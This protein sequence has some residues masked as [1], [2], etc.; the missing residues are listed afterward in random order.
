MSNHSLTAS[1]TDLQFSYTSVVSIRQYQNIICRKTLIC[2][3]LFVGHMV[4]SWSIK[5][6]AGKIA[7]NDNHT[8]QARGSHFANWG[9]H[10]GLDWKSSAWISK[11]PPT[12]PLKENLFLNGLKFRGPTLMWLS[13]TV[14]GG[15]IFLWGWGCITVDMT[16]EFGPTPA[17]NENNNKKAGQP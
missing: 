16:F 1:G 5:R 3:K 17:L 10:T 15:V 14:T 7:S 4:G 12:L 8:H 11:G 2:R 9:P 6:T 13:T